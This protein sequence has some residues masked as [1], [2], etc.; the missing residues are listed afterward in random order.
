MESLTPSH[1]VRPVSLWICQKY[2]SE[3]ALSLFAGDIYLVMLLNTVRLVAVKTRSRELEAVSQRLVS[4]AH[5]TAVK[6][7]VS[8]SI[9]NDLG[10]RLIDEK[11]ARTV[12]GGQSTKKVEGTRFVSP[13]AINQAHTKNPISF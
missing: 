7:V 8:T 2:L 1:D 13:M 11:I 4:V 6:M 10:G 9:N 5:C 3:E 12:A